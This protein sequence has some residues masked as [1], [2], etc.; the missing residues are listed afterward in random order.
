MLYQTHVEVHLD[1]IRENIQNIREKIGPDC[2]LLIPLKANAYGHGAVRVGRMAERN[3]ADYFGV[4][5]V[6]EG[7]ELREAGITKPI[8]LFTPIF[9]EEIEAALIHDFDLPV[10]TQGRADLIQE[11]AEKLGRKVRVHM[12]F[13]TG[14]GRVGTSEEDI[15]PLVSHILNKCPN[16]MLIGAMTHL[17]ASDE[18]NRAFT[19][20]QIDKF[21]KLIA[22]VESEFSF[23]FKLKH[24][25]NS[26]GIL[27]YPEAYMDMVRAGIMTYG[28]YPSNEVP[29]TVPLKFG[30]SFK[31]RLSFIKRI[32][33]GT[34]IGYNRTWVAPED[35]WIGTFP[36]GYADGFSRL[37]SNMGRVLVNGKSYPIVGRICMD[38]AMCNLGTDCNAKLGD[39]VVLI[40]SSG[41]EEITAYEWGEKLTSITY[42][43]TSRIH[44]RVPRIYTGDDSEE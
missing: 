31:T 42:E 22:E 3:G 27:A 34:S 19:E 39:E 21:K 44:S 37:F 9:L 20:R 11:V 33:A 23:K 28:F 38:Q 32:K 30:M 1:H 8:M 10:F 7:I 15:K 2:K 16:L 40:G 13:E 26:A 14:M 4:A 35:V 43:V 6:P 24:A 29:Q 25:A 12:N 17:P 36:A 5:T 41:N 18:A